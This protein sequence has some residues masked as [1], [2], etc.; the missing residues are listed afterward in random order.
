VEAPQVSFRKPDDFAATPL[1][2]VLTALLD[3]AAS[4]ARAKI[5]R[6]YAY[7]D[8]LDRK[9]SSICTVNSLLLAVNGLL[10]FRPPPSVDTS[11]AADL[12]YW[13]TYLLPF[14]ILAIALSLATVVYSLLVNSMK[15]PFLHGYAQDRAGDAAF[16]AEIQGLCNVISSRTRHVGIQGRLTIGSITATVVA[17]Y[18]ICLHTY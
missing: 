10:I 15:W 17:L 9:A 2:R 12:E 14:G 18:L 5:E 6:L 3:P 1:D 13:K 16:T 8:I 7:L 4:A 11:K